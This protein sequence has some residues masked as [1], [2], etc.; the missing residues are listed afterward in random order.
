[1]RV[2]YV[3]TVIN[4]HCGRYIQS[5]KVKSKNGKIYTS[6]LLCTKYR[7]DSKIKIKVEDL[8]SVL[9]QFSNSQLNF[10]DFAMD[11]S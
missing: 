11:F 9:A 3:E 5:N 4:Y 6:T 10:T 7:Q 8:Y 2:V 1:M